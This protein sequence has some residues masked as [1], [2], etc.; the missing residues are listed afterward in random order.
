MGKCWGK[1]E[2][3]TKLPKQAIELWQNPPEARPS[4]AVEQ[5]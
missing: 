5:R 3:E 1:R 2:E 4:D